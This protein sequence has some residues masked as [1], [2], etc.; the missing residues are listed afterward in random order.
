M[1]WYDLVYSVLGLTRLG[2]DDLAIADPDWYV[3]TYRRA[4]G[5]CR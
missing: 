2:D 5:L 4:I 1:L 3:P